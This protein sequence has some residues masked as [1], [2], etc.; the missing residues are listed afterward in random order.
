MNP[1]LHPWTISPDAFPADGFAA[2]QLE[3]LLGYAILA[4]SPHNTQPWQFRI[5]AMDVEVYADWG[6]RLRVVDPHGRELVLSCGAA[7]FNLRV[8]AEY[9]EK[10]WRLER[11]PDAAHPTLLARF[12]LGMQGETSSD[13]V[14][15]FNAITR[16]HTHRGTFRP[17][18]L[19]EGLLA[20]LVAS[21]EREGCWLM[22]A[23]TDEARAAIGD[24]VA[25]ADRCQWADRHFRDELA[26]WLRKD[27]GHSVDGIPV[28]ELG[29]EDWLS[30][31]GPSLIRTFDRGKGQAA[32]DRDIAVHSPILAVLGTE[33]DDADS[34]LS[35][36]QGMQNV[37]LRARAEDVWASFL[38]QPLE[39]PE[40]RDRLASICGRPN[41]QVVLRLG[42]ADEASPTPRRGVRSLLLHQEAQRSS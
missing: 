27:P 23:D 13:D 24:L 7:L 26:R 37:L 11:F 36:G 1:H 3:F 20:N 31:A 16:R 5:N 9:F 22:A 34:W 21:A 17:D 33:R 4:P 38:C 6:K 14:V 12:H 28:H 19:P 32:R 25:D 2:D 41:P 35:A 10:A 15:L 39:V 40:L 8:A 29:I 18:P 42:Y 30:F